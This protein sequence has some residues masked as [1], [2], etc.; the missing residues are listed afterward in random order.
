[1]LSVSCILLNFYIKPQPF[2]RSRLALIGCIL[3]NFY[4]KPQP[5][6]TVNAQI[7]VVSY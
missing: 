6:Q 1:M 4:I 7:V 2:G 3:L 5:S